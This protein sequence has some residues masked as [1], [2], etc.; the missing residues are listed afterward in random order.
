MVYDM[1]ARNVPT[2]ETRRINFAAPSALNTEVLGNDSQT[3]QGFTLVGSQN[4][5][6]RAIVNL[7]ATD[8]TGDLILKRDG[9]EVRRWP[10]SLLLS[11]Q[12]GPVFPGF[13]LTVRPGQIQF[14]FEQSAGTAAAQSVDLVWARSLIVVTS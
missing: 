10:S 11:S 12:Q 14:Y 1:S 6:M 5:I 7:S 4:M 9:K 2:P 3:G 8:V 13:P